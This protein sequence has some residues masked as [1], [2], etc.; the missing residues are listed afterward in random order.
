MEHEEKFPNYILVW[1]VLLLLTGSSNLASALVKEFAPVLEM[2][3]LAF[4]FLVGVMKA[5]LVAAN[6]MH[7]RFESKLLWALGFTAIDFVGFFIAGTFFD[8]TATVKR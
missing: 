5:S 7:L 3:L 1:I 6:F 8:I 2:A 4:L